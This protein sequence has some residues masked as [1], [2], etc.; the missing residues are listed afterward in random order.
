MQ[1]I[2]RSFEEDGKTVNQLIEDETDLLEDNQAIRNSQAEH[3][4]Y[5]NGKPMFRAA[6]ISMVM[7]E[8]MANGQCCSNGTS[9]KFLTSDKDEKKRALLHIQGSH[10]EYLLVK[11]KPFAKQKQIW[12]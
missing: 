7:I 3:F 10:P 9:Y 4:K 8:R 2:R 12:I 6:S 1:Q 11:G 5:L